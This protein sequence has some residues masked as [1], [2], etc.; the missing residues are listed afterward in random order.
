VGLHPGQHDGRLLP[1]LCGVSYKLNRSEAVES[2]R[3]ALASEGRAYVTGAEVYEYG[4]GLT[5]LLAD[6]GEGCVAK[7]AW[8]GDE[9]L[10]AWNITREKP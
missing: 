10:D 7:R 2:L 5:G 6:L 9:P 1:L 8:D 3:E 4:K